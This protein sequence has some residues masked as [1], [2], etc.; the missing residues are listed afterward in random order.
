MDDVEPMDTSSPPTEDLWEAMDTSPPY[1]EEDEAM[2]MSP[3]FIEDAEEPMDT[4]PYIIDV[5]EKMDTTPPPEPQGTPPAGFWA[6]FTPALSAHP[7][8][9][10]SDSPEPMDVDPPV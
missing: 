3:P 9:L 6:S 2:D 8:T 7:W 10:R 1:M 5:D 4:S